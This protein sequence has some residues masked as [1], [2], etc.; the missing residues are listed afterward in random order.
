MLLSLVAQDKT[1]EGD[2]QLTKP[3]V[4]R[5]VV[6]VQISSRSGNRKIRFSKP[7]SQTTEIRFAMVSKTFNVLSHR[8][9]IILQFHRNFPIHNPHQVMGIGRPNRNS[10]RRSVSAM[11]KQPT[12]TKRT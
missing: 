11:A 1:M 5:H 8:V 2:T 6:M 12:K 7:K 10:V 9:A 4:E 3:F